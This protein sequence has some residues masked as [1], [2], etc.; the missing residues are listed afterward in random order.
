MSKYIWCLQIKKGIK[1]K[2]MGWHFTTIDGY[3]LLKKN[4]IN[5][6]FLRIFYTRKAAQEWI[7]ELY[8]SDLKP[9]KLELRISK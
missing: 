1:A 4:R 3:R 7:G 5:K 6:Q 2:R 8:K 9:I